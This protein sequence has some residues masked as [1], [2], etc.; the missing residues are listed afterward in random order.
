ME[1]LWHI[2][3]LFELKTFLTCIL[4]TTNVAAAAVYDTKCCL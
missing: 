4:I 2:F 3:P 1:G